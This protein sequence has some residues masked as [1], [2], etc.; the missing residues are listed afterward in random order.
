MS[1]S[2]VQIITGEY[3]ESSITLETCLRT[4]ALAKCFMFH[5]SKYSIL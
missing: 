4:W 5:V 2:G 3:P 1:S